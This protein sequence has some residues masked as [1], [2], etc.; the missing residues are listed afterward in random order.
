[1]ADRRKLPILS[2]IN[3]KNFESEERKLTQQL[4]GTIHFQNEEDHIEPEIVEKEEYVETAEKK[5][6]KRKPVWI[7]EDDLDI[8]LKDVP[9]KQEKRVDSSVDKARCSSNESYSTFL[10]KQHANVSFTPAWADLDRKPVGEED[11]DPLLRSVGDYL[12]DKT[13]AL[14]KGVLGYTRMTDINKE[15]RSEGSKI[16]SLEFHKSEPVALVGGNHG[17]VTLFKVDGKDNPK[18]QSI[19]FQKFPLTESSFAANGE[20]IISTSHI[21]N[22]FHSYNLITGKVSRHGWNRNIEKGTAKKFKVSPDGKILA[23]FG[24]FGAIHILSAKTKEWVDTLKMNGE[25]QDIAF[26]LDGSRMFSFGEDGEVYIWDMGNRTCIHRFY[27]DGCIR[28]TSLC[29]SPNEQYLATGSSVGIVNIYDTTKI[30]SSAT[31]KPERI[32]SNL[33]TSVNG[34]KFNS[35]SEMLA[36]S[37]SEKENSVRL[38]HFPSYTVFSNFPSIQ[39]NCKLVRSL[40]FSPNGSFFAVGNST[41]KALLF[42]LSHYKEY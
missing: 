17:I 16:I 1:M 42:K 2:G 36:M 40:D 29:L 38:V 32:L 12:S 23:F 5:P 27:D 18:L 35:T 26:N 10:R 31:P 39:A 20:E 9:V 41:G 37:S 14:P 7:D 28:G 33:V 4:F 24:R 21:Q 3:S 15:T 22:H 11:D 19:Q 6:L 30:I 34:L 25:V 13:I 8:K